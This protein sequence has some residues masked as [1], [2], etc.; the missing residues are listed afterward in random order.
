MIKQLRTLCISPCRRPIITLRTRGVEGNVVMAQRKWKIRRSCSGQRPVIRGLSVLTR[1]L[2]LCCSHR[3]FITTNTLALP[4]HRLSKAHSRLLLPP[5]SIIL[6][7]PLPPPTLPRLRRPSG[8]C[9]NT[10]LAALEMFPLEHY[11]WHLPS[12]LFEIHQPPVLH[13]SPPPACHKSQA[14]RPRAAPP[15]L[16]FPLP[17]IHPSPHQFLELSETPVVRVSCRQNCVN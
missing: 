4:Q 5:L 6:P 11:P 17:C 16:P 12:F 10:T 8:V 2:G 7:L 1:H 15:L 13:L 3:M 9:S 14:L